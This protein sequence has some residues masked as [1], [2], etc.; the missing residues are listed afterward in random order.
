MVSLQFQIFIH[1]QIVTKACVLVFA[2]KLGASG[3]ISERREGKG[4]NNSWRSKKTKGDT[5]GAGQPKKAINSASS[6]M[7]E[8]GTKKKPREGYGELPLLLHSQC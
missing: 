1:I 8:V 3:N 2:Y 5:V 6:I 7:E 4:S